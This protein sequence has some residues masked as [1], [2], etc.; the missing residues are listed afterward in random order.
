M[1][2]RLLVA[3]LLFAVCLPILAKPKKK[4]YDNGAT[5]L[6]TAA[7]RTAR[8]RHVVT[9]VDEKM[10][11]FTFQT[12]HSFFTKGFIAN[13]SIEPQDEN[14]ATLIINV[15][16]K[17]GEAAWGAGDRMADKFFDQVREELAGQVRQKSSVKSEEASVTVAPPKAV[18]AEPSL[19]A[20][21]LTAPGE[22]ALGTIMLSATPENADVSVDGNF[23]G[24]APVN[25][26]LTPGKHTIVVSAKGYQGLTREITVMPDSEVRLTA[27]LEK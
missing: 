12:G 1:L 14:R 20:A 18:P 10:L 24:N 5:D 3:S 2:K 4:M 21:S 19:T 16:T 7:V 9:Y 15:Q 8:E 26:K 25:L 17:D 22:P 6:F 23:V 11:M 27:N 13:A